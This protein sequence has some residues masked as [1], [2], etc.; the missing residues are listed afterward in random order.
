M[1]TFYR[2]HII[3]FLLLISACGFGQVVIHYA[4][5]LTVEEG[6]SSNKINDVLQDDNGFLW[7]ATSYGLNRY[8]GENVVHFVHQDSTASI[9]DDIVLSLL[10]SGSHHLLI[11]TGKGIGVM[12]LNTYSI[13]TVH[14]SGGPPHSEYDDD[15]ELLHRDLHGNIWATTPT[16][17][18]RLNEDLKVLDHY[19]TQKDPILARKSNVLNLL[20]LSSGEELFWLYNGL[21]YWSP[22]DRKLRLLSEANKPQLNFLKE[23]SFYSVALADSRYLARIYGRNNMQILDTRTGKLAESHVDIPKNAYLLTINGV[24]GD[25]ISVTTSSTGFMFYK[26][27]DQGKGPDLHPLSENLLAGKMFQRVIKDNEDNYWA[28]PYSGGL[29]KM[30]PQKQL[31][32]HLKLMNTG[33]KEYEISGFFR[34]GK[35]LFIGTFGNGFY[36]YDPV[37]GTIDQHN[38]N[39]EAYAENMVWDFWPYHQDT[40]WIGTQQGLIWCNMKN[41]KIGRVTI[42]HPAVMDSV[43]ITTMYED[44]HGLVWMGIGRGEGVATYDK[45]SK[46]FTWYRN[47]PGGYPYRYPLGALEDRDGNMWFVSDPTG[48]LVKWNRDSKQFNKVIVPGIRGELDWESGGFFIDKEKNE[49][50]F[51]V[52]SG[53][54]IQYKIDS[55]KSIIYG[56]A[57]GYTSGAIAG[58]TRDKSGRLWLGNNQGISCF[59]PRTKQ[60]RNFFKRDGLPASYFSSQLYFD[61]STHLLYAGAPGLVS[62]FNVQEIPSPNNPLSIVLTAVLVNNKRVAYEG[63]PLVL[64]ADQNNVHVF[65]TGVNLVNGSEN[66]YAYRIGKSPWIDLGTQN[67]IN[68]A[69]LNPGSYEIAIRGAR[70]NEQFTGIPT[71]LSFMIR[72]HFTQ[73]IWFFVLCIIAISAIFFTVYKYR[74]GYLRKVEKMRARI[75][76]DLHDEIG[77]RVTNIG[78]MSAI[79]G[80]KHDMN[81]NDWLQ[82]IQAESQAVTQN[83]REIVW[84]INPDNDVLETALPR[85]LRYAS[86]FLESA[87]ITVRAELSELNG[88]RLDMEKRRDLFLIIK[89]A[90]NNIVRHSGAQNAE[91][92]IRAAKKNLSI[93]IRDDGQGFDVHAG[94]QG[95][96]LKNMEARAARHHWDFQLTSLPEMG[97]RVTVFIKIM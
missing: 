27:V 73:T 53:R 34:I 68:F 21:Y 1:A 87:G 26:I 55:K 96:G 88:F 23:S 31:F 13:T 32:N 85:I 10:L 50:W 7:I 44:S 22:D 4:E 61:S 54:L 65:F 3:N 43:A 71:T 35:F 66:Q 11:G 41:F 39:I 46:K 67:E 58:I 9:P 5:P 69:S 59:D 8:D 91:I 30:S 15:I 94:L 79:A 29:L 56:I 70:K 60:F 95:H 36:R 24:F 17:I 28:A 16:M 84:N 86:G 33:I 83:L 75:S 2:I 18:Y 89:E 77:S 92:H 12:D 48:N 78:M 37:S 51:G 82:K 80:Q 57:D 38:A 14:L 93:V 49:I 97:T 64:G 20:S 25:T 63:D 45:Y 90:V 62:W 19:R 52:R 42:P 6:L 47:E 81:D 40:I 76:R 72:P 74:V